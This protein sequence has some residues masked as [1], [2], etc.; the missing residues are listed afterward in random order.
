MLE[1]MGDMAPQ[2]L[3][4]ITKARALERGGDMTSQP[5]A[6]ITKAIMLNSKN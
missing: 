1:G 5:I 3:S 4:L 2:P 6:V